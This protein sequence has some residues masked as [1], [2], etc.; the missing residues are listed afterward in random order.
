MKVRKITKK[1]FISLENFKIN[2]NFQIFV[3]RLN[4]RQVGPRW[5]EITRYMGSCALQAFE[6]YYQM[7][8]NQNGFKS[9]KY[10]FVGKDGFLDENLEKS[11]AQAAR[12]MRAYAVSTVLFKFMY[13]CKFL[14]VRF[15]K[16]QN[17]RALLEREN[18]FKVPIICNITDKVEGHINIL[19]RDER[20]LYCINTNERSKNKIKLIE[21]HEG[22]IS[23][24]EEIAYNWMG[25]FELVREFRLFIPY[26]LEAFEEI[27]EE[28]PEILEDDEE[29]TEVTEEEYEEDSKEVEA[30]RYGTRAEVRKWLEQEYGDSIRL[31]KL[32]LEKYEFTHRDFTEAMCNYFCFMSAY[33]WVPGYAKKCE[34]ENLSRFIIPEEFSDENVARGLRTMREKE[35]AEKMNRKTII[36]IVI[37]I[38]YAIWTGTKK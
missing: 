24:L 12:Y 30:K 11:N 38:I 33:S 16:T 15:L 25:E 13:G 2:Q 3:D 9:I 35:K 7:L 6:I 19:Y 29:D 20:G 26:E 17:L 31:H 36:F 21:A 37:I 5:K 8:N 22:D 34:R 4:A 28:E 10:H 27:I 18:F 1:R 14:R 23:A 32:D